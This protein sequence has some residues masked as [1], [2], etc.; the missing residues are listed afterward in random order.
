MHFLQKVEALMKNDSGKPARIRD[1]AFSMLTLGNLP[2]M[3][4]GVKT[5]RWH[6]AVVQNDEIVLQ[7]RAQA[8]SCHSIVGRGGFS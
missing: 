1:I 6:N 7:V 2:P 3:V 5:V 8:F 4:T